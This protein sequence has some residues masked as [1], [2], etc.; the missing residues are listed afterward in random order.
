M[1]L[2]YIPHGLLYWKLLPFQLSVTDSPKSSQSTLLAWLGP[3]FHQS[4]P[5]CIASMMPTTSHIHHQVSVATVQRLLSFSHFFHITWVDMSHPSLVCVDTA[6]CRTA[7]SSTP[8]WIQMGIILYYLVSTTN[9]HCVWGPLQFT[10]D[11]HAVPPCCSW[12][13]A[14]NHICNAL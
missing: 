7:C 2:F 3:I 10:E 11:W 12:V 9:P 5:L 13:S 6:V 1:S 4:L 8:V 14:P